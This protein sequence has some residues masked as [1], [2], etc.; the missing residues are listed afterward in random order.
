MHVI[1]LTVA[2]VIRIVARSLNV[3]FLTEV[4]AAQHAV[5]VS[6]GSTS[7]GTRNYFHKHLARNL[8]C[9]LRIRGLISMWLLS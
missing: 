8:Q 1:T 2:A 4:A 6:N 3:V 9:I 5:C 7:C